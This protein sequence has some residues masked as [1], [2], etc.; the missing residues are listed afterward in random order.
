VQSEPS[1]HK[2]RRFNA[3]V[4]HRQTKETERRVTMEL[5]ATLE[6]RISAKTKESYYCIEIML[7]NKCMKRVFLDSA[8][9]ELM[10]LLTSQKNLKINQT[11]A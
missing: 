11:Q 3:R 2:T 7:T 4:G 10:E 9:S 5:K 8:E 6:K 1:Y